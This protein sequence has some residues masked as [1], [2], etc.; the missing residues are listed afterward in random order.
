MKILN[1]QGQYACANCCQLLDAAP[2]FSDIRE[3]RAAF[4]CTNAHFR[5]DPGTG[6]WIACAHYGMVLQFE[7][8]TIECEVVHHDERL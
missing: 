6:K 1:L 5:R 3:R 4:Y 7:I 8:P 2:G